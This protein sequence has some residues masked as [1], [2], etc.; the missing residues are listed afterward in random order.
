VREQVERGGPE[1]FNEGKTLDDVQKYIAGKGPLVFS[2]WGQMLYMPL[3]YDPPEPHPLVRVLLDGRS[4]DGDRYCAASMLPHAIWTGAV[5]P[6]DRLA[7][8]IAASIPAT[9]SADPECHDLRER[10]AYAAVHAASRGRQPALL[11]SLM[12]DERLGA[13][14]KLEVFERVAWMSYMWGPEAA[15]RNVERAFELLSVAWDGDDR[16]VARVSAERLIRHLSPE[17]LPL[18]FMEDVEWEADLQRAEEVASALRAW[19]E[20]F[21]KL[22]AFVGICF[23]LMRRPPRTT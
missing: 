8:S 22:P 23:L 9:R 13:T 17:E 11:E 21:R 7:E 4:S 19:L 3:R 18:F 6:S 15:L 14:G 16:V 5:E 12:N 1:H 2:P 10:L 20:R